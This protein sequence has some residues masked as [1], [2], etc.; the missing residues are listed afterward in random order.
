MKFI[1]PSFN[2]KI[3]KWK[4]N[5]E[6][7]VYVSTLG[8]FKD[9]HKCFLPLKISNNKG[10]VFIRTANGFKAA[11]RLVL[12]T[13]RPI[14]NAE[15]LIVDHKNHNKRDN[16]LE[17][18]EWVS[19]KENQRRAEK[20]R[21]YIKK[22][23]EKIFNSAKSISKVN[24]ESYFKESSK[25]ELIVKN[26]DEAVKFALALK[27]RAEELISKNLRVQKRIIKAIEEGRIYCNCR[28]FENADGT[29]K[30]VMEV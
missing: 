18:L 24:Y 26:L 17:N 3:E 13:F 20:D 21:V 6:Y 25:K 19:F 8:N 4:W 12:L 16:S 14:P 1:F 15:E 23:E 30:I 11:H 10:Y 29:V 27:G 22:E 7:R 2:F 28:W 9:E 5:S